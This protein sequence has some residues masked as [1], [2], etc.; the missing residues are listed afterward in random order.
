MM[1]RSPG[2]SRSTETSATIAT[3]VPTTAGTVM[4]AALPIIL[5]V[6]FVL[7]FIGHDVASIPRRPLH[8]K[9]RAARPDRTLRGS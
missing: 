8:L 2:R 7:A 3:G 4:V 9:A 1:K 6:Q 5:G